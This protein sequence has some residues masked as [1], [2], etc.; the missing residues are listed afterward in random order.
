VDIP[1]GKNL[2]GAFYQPK[3]VYIDSLVL[4]TL[5]TKELLNGLAEVIKYGVIRDAAFFAY[6]GRQREAILALD[7]PV[8]E[9]VIARCCSIKAEVVE[10]DERESDLRRILNYGHTIGH[11]VEA[12]SGYS[13]EHGS[14]V[15]IGMVAVNALAVAK[16]LIPRE[17]ADQV[18]ELIAAYGLAVDIPAEYDRRQIKSYLKTDKKTVG[19][20][21]FFVL[22]TRIG[23]VIVTDEVDD[24][25]VDRVIGVK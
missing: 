16:G 23:A 21:S 12:A 13:L 5:P 15:A 11:A 24:D 20:R 10:A 25:L 6:L 1:E 14:A 17:T 9:K 18:Q 19:G 22:P 2:V 8:L 4:K 7:L 3:C